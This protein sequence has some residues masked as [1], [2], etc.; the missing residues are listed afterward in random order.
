MNS[1]YGRSPRTMG[2][3]ASAAP[4]LDQPPFP[5]LYVGDLHPNVSELQLQY[6]FSPCGAISSIHVCR[7]RATGA[8]LQY[9]YVNF[10]SFLDA[11]K[12]LTM[13]NHYPLNGRPIRI[14]W[15]QRNPLSRRNGI[16][17]L[18][19]NN[20]DCVDAIALE[21]L[22][23]QYGTV[24]SCKLAMDESG[25]SKGFGFVQ[26]DTEEAAQSAIRAL[27]GRFLQG[28]KKKL[29]VTKFVKQDERQPLPERQNKTNLYIKNLDW[30][31]TDE[32]L[33]MRF[34][35]YGTIRSFVVMKKKDGKSRGFGFVDFLSAEDAKNA[36]ND[37]NGLKFGTRT[38]YVGYAQ[39]KKQRKVLLSRLFGGT[40]HGMQQNATIFVRN[41][42][43]SVDG[44]A[45]REHF[46]ASGKI[47]CAR[48]IY[49][50]VNGQSMGFGFVRFF[51]TEEAYVAVQ[52]FN[53]TIFHGRLLYVAFA[54][55][56]EYMLK[57]S[58]A[59]IRE[60]F[61]RWKESV[62]PTFSSYEWPQNQLQTNALFHHP[63]Y[64]MVPVFVT[65][66]EYPTAHVVSQS[67][68]TIQNKHGEKLVGLL[69]Y[70]GSRKLVIACHGF[71]SSKDE[72]IFVSLA[73]ALTN[74][75]I[76]VF[77][78]DFA[79]NGRMW[80][81]PSKG[82]HEGV[83][84]LGERGGVL[85]EEGLLE[86]VAKQEEEEAKLA[87]P[88]EHYE[89]IGSRLRF[90]YDDVETMDGH[91]ACIVGCFMRNRWI[92]YQFETME[93]RE[94]V[95]LEGPYFAYGI[96]IFLKLMPSCFLFNVDGHFI[97]M[98][99]QIHDLSLDCWS[100]KVLSLIG[101]EIGNP[102]YTDQMTRTR[103]RLEYARLMM[104]I[105]V[106]GERVE[107]VPITLP[108]GVQLDLKVVYE[109]V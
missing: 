45:L 42:E 72:K 14:M 76:S 107:S 99:I 13:M 64:G 87:M 91:W 69:H 75:G 18:F 85:K 95:V 47:W 59:Q 104:G 31:I 101:M 1:G 60:Q 17:N 52:R 94:K 109:M 38:V 12:A 79:G 8:S 57:I 55:N 70:N 2:E 98:W 46:G 36:L 28:S 19:V 21:N 77:R 9:A 102:L 20:L 86:A 103:D 4:P 10:F 74:Q 29:Y 53:G 5:T 108:T 11:K 62:L 100:S 34:S 39:T 92:V 66:G 27:N 78:F 89:A 73:S 81:I 50:K 30:A 84:P 65:Q 32:V 105:A 22:F 96:P 90:E 88:L 26:M 68:I 7:D 48:V 61:A 16:G 49:N 83:S 40:Q 25:K 93:D 33:R 41:L 106:I 63:Q 56:K 15:S 54:R 51:S 43:E 71:R 24:K 23:A 97:P 6:V 80:R 35:Q 3:A 37:M 44:K 82:S 58:L 67:K